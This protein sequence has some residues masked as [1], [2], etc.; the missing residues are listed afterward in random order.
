M[1]KPLGFSQLFFTFTNM[2]FHW[3]SQ[4]VNTTSAFL[5]KLN[6]LTVMRESDG[7]ST[8]G[9]SG[10]LSLFRQRSFWWLTRGIIV[11]LLTVSFSLFISNSLGVAHAVTSPS[12]NQKIFVGYFQSWSEKWADDPQQLQ[13]AKLPPYVNVVVVSFMNPNGT[14]ISDG[15]Y[16]LTNT[17]LIFSADGTVV[18]DA[19]ALLKTRNPNTKVLLGVGGSTYRKY[20]SLLNP[21]AIANVVRDFGFDGVDIDYEPY[22]N[23]LANC[24]PTP[25]RNR[26][27]CDTDD[28]FR[29]IVRE[30]RTALNEISTPPLSQTPYLVMLAAWSIGAYGEGQWINS[31]PRYPMTGLM[32]NLL[33][34]PE[35]SMIDIL[36]VMSYNAGIVPSQYNPQEALAAY[37][38]YFQGKIAMG[39]QVPPE[40]GGSQNVYTLAKV[41]EL[42]QAVVDRNA[43]G[44]MM[45]SLQRQPFIPPDTYVRP[46]QDYPNAEMIA[47]TACTILSLGN[48]SEPL[49]KSVVTSTSDDGSATQLGTLS[50][51]L[52]YAI[53]GETITFALPT[54]NTVYVTNKLPPV[55]T[56]V[57]IDGGACTVGPAITIDGS[58]IQNNPSAQGLVLSGQDTL[59]SLKVAHFPGMEITNI[60]GGNK[61]SCV[62]AID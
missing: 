27:F 7:Q 1:F 45:W 6:Q 24:R 29:R 59:H 43:D 61:L 14:Y 19:I 21:T 28:D 41:R 31:M 55:D 30:I 20:F 32:L 23:G 3:L 13:L 17:G 33:R 56:G 42:T 35:A 62:Q 4:M 60:G 53:T 34:S 44:I 25:P 49:F 57:T 5:E 16:D 48:C 54:G 50:N 15:N 10:Q 40:D 12:N 22:D 11:L 38:H 18:K 37:Q 2:S 58:G 47:Q 39:V 46:T 9:A 8:I 36:S 52:E 51:A 26:I